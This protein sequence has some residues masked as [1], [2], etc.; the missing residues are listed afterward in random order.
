MTDTAVYFARP[1]LTIGGAANDALSSSILSLTTEENTDGLC[2]CEVRV[3]NFGTRNDAA[4]YL[5]LGRDIVDFGT[6]LAVTAGPPE[7]SREV[8]RGKVSAL[9]ATYP[10]SSSAELTMFAEDRLMKLRMTRRTRTFEDMSDA[11][12]ARQ[13]ANDHSLTPEIDMDGP[14]HRLV[15]QVNRSDLAFLR[16]RA[17]S[18]GGEVWVEGSNLHA[19]A[20]QGRSGERLELTYGQR[21]MSFKVRADLA[22]QYSEVGVAGWDVS[23]KDAIDETAD[24]SELGSELDGNISGSSIL[25]QKLHSRKERLVRAVPVAGD[26]ARSIAR[27]MFLRQAR[28]F[29]SGTALADGN[30]RIRVGAAIA[31]AGLGGLFSGTYYVCRVR[32]LF[33]YEQGFRTE[34]DVERP[35]LGEGSP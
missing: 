27:A 10:M 24:D 29:V 4:Q 5:W 9:E 33:D 16:D 28:R 26:E 20:R 17:R 34:F 2:W 19:S 1:K 25:E 31:F 13:I 22:H 21:L 35:G 32:H 18:L 8:F 15:A 12:I 3:N 6:E 14:T 30:P 11:D 23:A 7:S